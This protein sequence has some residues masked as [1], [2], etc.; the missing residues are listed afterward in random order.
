[1]AKKSQTQL[2][3]ERQI[4][5][6]KQAIRRNKK[7]GYV[8]EQ[9]ILP[10]RPTKITKK[11]VEELKQ[12][13]PKKLRH[14][15]KKVDLETGEIQ[16]PQVEQPSIHNIA[17]T[18]YDIFERIEDLIEEI[19][20]KI[21]CFSASTG[22]WKDG[23]EWQKEFPL[24]QVFIKA[25]KEYNILELE[26][27]YK[28]N[29]QELAEKLTIWKYASKQEIIEQGFSQAQRLLNMNNALTVQEAQNLGN[30]IL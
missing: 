23:W 13:T 7:K 26:E 20:Y 19:P 21:P 16:E 15:S 30:A 29:E 17:P 10:P 4:K 2:D 25:M 3:Y 18:A 11:D 12:L 8:V 1:M 14:V 9:D 6:I 28:Q 22:R 24:M 27:F 5:R